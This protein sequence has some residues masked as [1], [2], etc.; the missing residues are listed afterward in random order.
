M[1]Y[2]LPNKDCRWTTFIALSTLL[3]TIQSFIWKAYET[4]IMKIMRAILKSFIRSQVEVI[5]IRQ[6]KYVIFTLA[7]RKK[8]ATFFCLF[9]ASSSISL[10]AAC[11]LQRL[12]DAKQADRAIIRDIET[13]TDN[14]QALWRGC[15][16]TFRSL[17]AE[18]D[19]PQVQ[20]PRKTQWVIKGSCWCVFTQVRNSFFF[21]LQHTMSRSTK[22]YFAVHNIKL[23]LW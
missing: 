13:Q 15:S 18:S 21:K 5:Y 1:K 11:I 9:E 14:E 17:G 2:L 12:L 20:S 3:L 22:D 10:L 6:S 4:W 23:C 7:Y 19:T 8:N 16:F